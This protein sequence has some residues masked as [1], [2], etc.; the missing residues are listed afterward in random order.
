M[1]MLPLFSERFHLT[2]AVFWGLTFNEF[3]AYIQYLHE[4][5]NRDS[6]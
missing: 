1:R 2:P 6:V 4:V 3:D 5:A